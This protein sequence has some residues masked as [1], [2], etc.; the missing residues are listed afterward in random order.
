MPDGPSSPDQT[1][2]IDTSAAPG[3]PPTIETPPP[4]SPPEQV[5]VPTTTPDVSVDEV[6]AA[7]VERAR[8]LKELIPQLDPYGITLRPHPRISREEGASPIVILSEPAGGSGDKSFRF[9]AVTERGIRIVDKPH[10]RDVGAVIDSIDRSGIIQ[11]ETNYS[12]VFMNDYVEYGIAT[13]SGVVIR[14]AM[15]LGRDATAEE[16]MQ[17]LTRSIQRADSTAVTTPPP[18]YSDLNIK[19][20]Y[21]LRNIPRE[22]ARAAIVMTKG[23]MG[24]KS[25]PPPNPFQEAR[26]QH[27]L[28]QGAASD[29]LKR[30][31]ERYKTDPSPTR[32]DESFEAY[33]ARDLAS[34]NTPNK[35][36]RDAERQRIDTATR[37]TELLKGPMATIQPAS[38][39]P[40]SQAA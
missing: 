19:D 12:T 13:K 35:V 39:V 21:K 34:I 5:A 9:L 3:T 29:S 25:P 23:G 14:E 22:I 18:P 30:L 10:V 36:A 15:Y 28:E 33:V 11:D 26:T 20:Q 7:S 31:R 37:M 38:P 32:P 1:E 24:I 16:A 17:A 27:S 8:L 4:I 2:Q 6:N 40:T